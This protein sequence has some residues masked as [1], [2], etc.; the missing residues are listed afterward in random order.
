[1]KQVQLM[2]ILNVFIK[3]WC[4]RSWLKFKSFSICKKE[5]EDEP[6]VPRALIGVLTKLQ[7]VYTVWR[8]VRR[9]WYLAALRSVLTLILDSKPTV[10]SSRY[11]V[12]LFSTKTRSGLREAPVTS[13]ESVIKV[14]D[15]EVE[16]IFRHIL[17][18][19]WPK[20]KSI[21]TS[22]KK[23]GWEDEALWL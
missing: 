2:A 6:K 5:S 11:S 14:L 19:L 12:V 18:H 7:L 13:N 22:M 8:F 4:Y 1:M 10:S 15:G 3:M 9:E 21:T 23:D 20:T 17:L 16:N